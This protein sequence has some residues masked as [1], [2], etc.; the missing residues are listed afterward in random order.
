MGYWENMN[1]RAKKLSVVDIKLAQWAAMFFGLTIVKIFPGI[2]DINV[3][4]FVLLCAL[5]ALKP[6]YVF[7]IKK[8]RSHT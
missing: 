4:W 6:G 7:W 8:A 1:K 2:M 5:C 3:W